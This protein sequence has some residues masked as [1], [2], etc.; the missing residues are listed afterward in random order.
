MM[1]C[2]ILIFLFVVDSSAM[3][4]ST[5]TSSLYSTVVY[6][7]LE[8]CQ[9]SRLLFYVHVVNNHLE[10]CQDWGKRDGDD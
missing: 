4:V 3:K 5:L 6:N 9:E 2:I 7:H 10:K 1:T 8:K